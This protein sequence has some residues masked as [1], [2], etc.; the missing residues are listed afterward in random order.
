MNC[1]ISMLN[2]AF[3]WHITKETNFQNYVLMSNLDLLKRYMYI[4]VLQSRFNT[5]LCLIS[6]LIYVL[7]FQ[8]NWKK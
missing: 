2:T 6:K 8:S 4:G 7:T 5:E 1:T 3:M